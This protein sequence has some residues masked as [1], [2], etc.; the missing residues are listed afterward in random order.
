MQCYPILQA[1]LWNIR[2]CK[3]KHQLC[4]HAGAVFAVELDEKAKLAYT[5]SGDRVNASP[6]YVLT[7]RVY[8]SDDKTM[9]GTQWTVH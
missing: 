2:H 5:G 6:L 1:V 3:L 7:I 4:G 9:G 8:H